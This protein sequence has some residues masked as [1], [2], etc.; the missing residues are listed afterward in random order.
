MFVFTD[1]Q[2]CCRG[3][4]LTTETL[5]L[6]SPHRCPTVASLRIFNNLKDVF[7]KERQY[8]TCLPIYKRR[9]GKLNIFT[10]KKIIPKHAC[11]APVN[12]N[13]SKIVNPEFIFWHSAKNCRLF[14]TNYFSKI[15]ANS[16]SKKKKIKTANVVMRLGCI[17]RCQHFLLFFPFF[18][19][20]TQSQCYSELVSS[21]LVWKN[22]KCL[23]T[24][25]LKTNKCSI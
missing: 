19:K 12:V 10:E 18:F 22:L 6:K 5:W 21:S 23:K 13:V 25:G 17:S 8:K 11:Y 9:N 24:D 4:Q 3:N 2:S 16:N 20:K 7:K 1:E 14:C 15:Y